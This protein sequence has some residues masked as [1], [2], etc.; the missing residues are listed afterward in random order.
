MLEGAALAA[1][2]FGHLRK[3]EGEGRGGA[4]VRVMVEGWWVQWDELKSKGWEGRGRGWQNLQEA[5]TA[6][7]SLKIRG[8]GRE[9]GVC[10]VEIK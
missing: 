1:F 10:A 7:S 4:G 8:G 5:F 2:I 6:L 3:G 9:V